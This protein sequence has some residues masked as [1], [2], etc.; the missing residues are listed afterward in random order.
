V[1]GERKRLTGSVNSTNMDES[2]THHDT[3]HLGVTGPL[4]ENGSRIHTFALYGVFP[5]GSTARVVC[6]VKT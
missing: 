5:G 1:F 6:D 3:S 4:S 2:M